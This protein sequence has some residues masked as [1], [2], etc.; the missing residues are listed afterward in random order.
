M[1]IQLTKLLLL[2]CFVVCTLFVGK[3]VSATNVTQQGH[4]VTVNVTDGNE[5]LIG[6]SVVIKGT[7]SGAVTNIDGIVSFDE[8]SSQDTLVISFIGY[9]TQKIGI[10][11]Q[12]NI[13]V[14]LLE[15]TQTV[16]DVVVVGY[17]T[18]KRESL[19]SAITAIDADE[20][21]KTKQANLVT[22]L[23]G[24]VSGLLIRQSGGTPGKFYSDISMRGYGTPIV[25]I[26]GIVR[27]ETYE[28][29]SG[30][31]VST[32]LAL[33]QLNPNDIE[34]I[35]VLKDAS[36]SIY[37]MG[38]GNGVILVTTKK[39]KSTKPTISYSNT[40]SFGSPK[41]PKPMGMVDYMNIAN[42]M[43][44]NS[45]QSH[46][47]AADE[48][49]DYRNGTKKS[50][51]WWDTMMK[52]FSSSQTHNVSI[53]GGS[54]KIQYFVSGGYV[55]DKSIYD[56]DDN[57]TYKRYT[58]RGNFTAKL[59]DDLTMDYQT[60]LRSTKSADPYNTDNYSDASSMLFNYIAYADR[61]VGA[62][63]LDNPNHY[64]YQ[65]EAPT[66]NPLAMADHN[67]NYTDKRGRL[68]TNNINLKYEAP[69]LKGLTMQVTGAYDF[70]Y[71]GTY[72]KETT[73]PLYDYYTD[74]KVGDGGTRNYYGETIR[75]NERYNARFQ[76]NYD[77]RKEN[78]HV[79]GMLAAEVTK[80]NLRILEASREFGDFYTHNTVSSGVASTAVAEGKRYETATAG[81]LGRFNYDYA[82]KY[83]VEVMGRYDGTYI[84]ESGQRWG[85]FPSYS[86][87]WRVSEESF[88]KENFSWVDNLKL[89]WS[90]GKTGLTQ[91]DAYAY[92]SGYSVN[93]SYVFNSG[94]AID[95]YVNNEIANTILSWADIRMLDLGVDWDFFGGLFGG[96]FDVFARKTKGIAGTS[97][98]STPTI[99]GV[100]VP[101]I[102]IDSKIDKGLDFSL[103]HRNKIG[104]LSYDVTAT[105][106]LARTK[107]LHV[108]SEATALWASQDDYY[109]TGLFNSGSSQDRWSDYR[110]LWYF[111]LAGG[112]F[113]GW[114]DI[115]SSDV[116]YDASYGMQTTIPGQYVIEDVN[117][118]G[119]ITGEDIRYKW[120]E[121]NPPFQYG[122]R[123]GAQYGN[124]DFNM[125]WQGA[126]MSSKI[127]WLLHVFGY[128][129]YSENY[130]M[131][132]DRYHVAEAGANPFD[133]NTEWVGGY[134]PALVDASGP[135]VW[136]PGTYDTPTDFTQINA[137]YFR[138][139]SIE[140]GYTLPSEI[141]SKVGFSSARVYIGGTNLLTLVTKKMK[142]YDPESAAAMHG[143][144]M[145]NMRTMNFGMN[146][147]F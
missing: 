59:T 6:A 105:G 21:V 147:N 82:G 132:L 139:K 98:G 94:S 116:K 130:E 124:W 10:G 128:G 102:N 55:N 114:D 63:T 68:F 67:L 30:Y 35:T 40:F 22:A 80:T 144:T 43:A 38:A 108:E 125:V 137:T 127:I 69:F 140:L 79:A 1:K 119:F 121:T 122:L 37:G 33:A 89:R 118:D 95:G 41:M 27:S 120:G 138:M 135:G 26:D 23:Q 92:L 85:F 101:S 86:L 57:F 62:T 65:G 52:D 70:N 17:G 44:D 58:L 13:N 104:K 103:T 93:S 19:T 142:Y 126:T 34:S 109:G 28:N 47:Y 56:V 115:N 54:D 76:A 8:L 146:L 4:P 113:T 66:Y 53:R 3:K 131:Y 84:Y 77:W 51:D 46:P 143:S 9:V 36:A 83:L 91:G 32:D 71:N 29:T 42:E 12:T 20:V 2:T 88:I 78:H 96:S 72:N 60:S 123:V 111:P 106:T 49:E 15:N 117:G 145:P 99:L 112:Q 61:Q 129:G 136:R 97:S 48:I 7:T 74:E 50:F 5:P 141:L 81:Y 25:V 18:Q 11:A 64:T 45:G 133:P 87:G 107:N 110:A 90:D 14:L 16:A 31:G 100:T 39:G 24:K 73:Y 75:E 134:W